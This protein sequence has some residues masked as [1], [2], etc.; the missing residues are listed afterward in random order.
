PTVLAPSAAAYVDGANPVVKFGTAASL[1]VDASPVKQAYLRFDVR[2]IMPPFTVR[3]ARLRL[4]AAASSAAASPSGG[5]VQTI[6]AGNLAW[7]EAATT[8]ASRPALDGPMLATQ[9]AVS[10][11]QVVDLDVRGAAARDGEYG[12]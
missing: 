5:N 10:T 3:R 8:F 11:N 7:S 2:G 1:F 12:F 4:T 9:G 6:V